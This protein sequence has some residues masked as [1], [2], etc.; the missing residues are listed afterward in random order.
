VDKHKGELSLESVVGTG[1][2]L[3]LSIPVG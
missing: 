2:T 1:T 3:T